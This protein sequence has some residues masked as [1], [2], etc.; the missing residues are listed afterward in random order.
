M[1]LAFGGIRGGECE[2]SVPLREVRIRFQGLANR[3]DAAVDVEQIE[4]VTQSLLVETTC[5]CGFRRDRNRIR[6]RKCCSVTRGIL[7]WRS[8]FRLR[9]CTHAGRAGGGRDQRGD[10]CPL[11]EFWDCHVS[12]QWISLPN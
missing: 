6:P 5:F 3:V 1:V 11:S 12:S 7:R 2:H 9:A 10:K 8:A 4:I